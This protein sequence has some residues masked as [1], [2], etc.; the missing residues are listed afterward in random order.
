[1]AKILSASDVG[2]VPF[3]ANPLWKNALP[4]KALEYFA[5]SLPVVATIFT[6]SIL[7]KLITENKLG[8]ICEPENVTA[9]TNSLEKISND[10]VFVKNVQEKACYLIHERF[11][12]NKIALEF[13]NLFEE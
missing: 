6:D 11:D 8:L 1:L 13:L 9:L 2:I 10:P 4:S 7:G 3:D 5:C 12:R